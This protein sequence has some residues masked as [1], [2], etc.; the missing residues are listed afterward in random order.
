[1]AHNN[2]KVN[3]AVPFSRFNFRVLNAPEPYVTL[4]TRGRACVN[5]N[6]C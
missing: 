1:M 2:T 6:V 4:Q 3:D 5:E